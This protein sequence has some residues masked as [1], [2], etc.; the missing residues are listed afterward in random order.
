MDKK[1][2]FHLVTVSKSIRL[3]KGQIEYLRNKGFDV[4][5]VSSPGKE[6]NVYS[7]KIVHAINMEREISIKQDLISLF[8]MTKLFLKE[9]PYIV[10]SGTPKAGLIGTLAAYIT[11]RPVR[12]YTVRGLRLETVKGLKYRILYAMEKLA[13]FCA[14]DIIAVSESLKEKIVELDLEKKS[15]IKVLGYG[16]SNGIN[17]NNFKKDFNEIP[18]DLA[19]NLKDQFVIGFV[20]RIVKDKGIREMIEAFKLIRLKNKNIKLLILGDPEKDNS[21]SVEHFNIL[22]NDKDIILVGHVDKPVNY[23]NHMDVLV[24]PTYR[25]GFANVNLEAQALKIPVI[26]TNATGAKDTID[27]NVTG[28]V[29]KIGDYKDIANKVQILI[30][31]PNLKQQMGERAFSRVENKFTNEIIWKHLETIYRNKNL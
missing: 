15:K 3:M 22:K 28:Y 23:F 25:E 20:G 24:S 18:N 30:D 17:L 16:S 29:T 4:H 1:K 13:M 21:I 2:I 31:N 27:D 19:E 11:R 8:K 10:N 14:T 12:I 7:D 6:Q 9:K 5:V 26:T